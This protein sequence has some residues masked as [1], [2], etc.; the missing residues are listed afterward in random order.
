M[1]TIDNYVGIEP[2][3]GAVVK[4]T[5]SPPSKVK[6]TEFVFTLE[7]VTPEGIL[8]NIVCLP[9]PNLYKL[10]AS[11]AIV[12]TASLAS[13]NLILVV[14]EFRE[15]KNKGTKTT[16]NIPTIRRYSIEA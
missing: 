12:S 14:A 15:N 9:P 16:N 3:K 13:L 11:V 10:S 6:T 8:T 4:A 2:F 1:R 7:E 5:E